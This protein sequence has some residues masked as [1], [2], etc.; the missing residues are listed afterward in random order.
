[1]HAD[2]KNASVIWTG[3]EKSGLTRFD[4]GGFFTYAVQDGL[5]SNK[6]RSIT[7]KTNGELVIACYDAGVATF[8][9]KKI[10]PIQ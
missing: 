3:S 7:Q 1:M 9:G 5:P 2:R 8:D 6:I 4:S 10:P